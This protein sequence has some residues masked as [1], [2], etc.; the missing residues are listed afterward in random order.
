M[1]VQV[2][3]KFADAIDG[4]DLSAVNVGDIVDLKAHEAA[5][6]VVEGW[7]RELTP[8]LARHPAPQPEE[9]PAPVRRRPLA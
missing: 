5:L 9:L 1:R 8:A 3:R 6:L 7:A 4:I 2:I